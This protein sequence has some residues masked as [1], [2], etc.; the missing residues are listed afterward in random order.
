MNRRHVVVNSVLGV[1]LVGAG[2]GT[3]LSVSSAG[4]S[5]T[6]AARTVTVTTGNLTSTV[7]ATGNA[8]VVTTIGAVLEGSASG[9]VQ[10]IYVKEGQKV[11]KGQ[12]GRA[13]V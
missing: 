1:A 2:L 12:I 5:S 13:H 4:Q 9:V 10:T 7:T 11:T 6:P 3:Y 8:E